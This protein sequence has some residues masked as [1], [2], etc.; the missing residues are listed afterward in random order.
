MITKSLWTKAQSGVVGAKTN[1]NLS[2]PPRVQRI[3]C[4]G[5]ARTRAWRPSAAC[6]EK[7]GSALTLMNDPSRRCPTRARLPL[8]PDNTHEGGSRGGRGVALVWVGLRSCPHA[9]LSSC[10]CFGNRC[11]TRVNGVDVMQSGGGQVFWVKWQRAR[12]LNTLTS[13]QPWEAPP[14]PA[15]VMG[16]STVRFQFEALL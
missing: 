5:W 11:I 16:K 2:R 15:A 4:G 8:P 12:G 3:V 13:A 6:Q 1:L 14:P 10:V 9:P 7:C